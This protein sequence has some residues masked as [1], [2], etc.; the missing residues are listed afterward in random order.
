VIEKN[1]NNPDFWIAKGRFLR[2]RGK[3]EQSV[4]YFAQ[5]TELAPDNPGRVLPYC[6][7]LEQ[8]ERVEDALVLAQSLFEKTPDHSAVQAMLV[9]LT[10]LDDVEKGQALYQT[11]IEA[12][13]A[14]EDRFA[15][16]AAVLQ[17]IGLEVAE[18]DFI[19]RGTYLGKT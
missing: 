2:N 17:D 13:L 6:E 10:L 5:G 8:V 1:K 15:W 9:R 18:R 14:K 12:R 16:L 11:L 7:I 4:S 19:L 3:L